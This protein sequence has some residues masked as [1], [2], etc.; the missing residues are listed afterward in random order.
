MD[1][2]PKYLKLAT[3]LENILGSKNVYYQP[4][5]NV[6]MKYPCIVFKLSSGDSQFADNKPY[7]YTDRYS[8][9]LISKDPV[10]DEIHDKIVHL[11]MCIF[12]RP[13]TKNNLNHWNYYIYF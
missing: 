11:P 2:T 10:E 3:I 12:D 4:P 13:F 1:Q 7:I 9:Q 6:E 8:I 5:P